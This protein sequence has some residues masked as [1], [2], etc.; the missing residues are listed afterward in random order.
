MNS[1]KRKEKSHVIRRHRIPPCRKNNTV[2]IRYTQLIPK[3][4]NIHTIKDESRTPSYLPHILYSISSLQCLQAEQVTHSTFPCTSP[5][6]SL[7]YNNYSITS[8]YALVP[9]LLHSITQKPKHLIF[10]IPSS[11]HSH[12]AYSSILMSPLHLH[13]TTRRLNIQTI[14]A[15]PFLPSNPAPLTDSTSNPFLFLTGTEDAFSS[16]RA[17]LLSSLWVKGD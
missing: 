3:Q 15:S 7:S 4:S 10:V 11:L 13:P 1:W 5:L 2:S 14:P 8:S 12:I 17:S 16:Y 6:P 9:R